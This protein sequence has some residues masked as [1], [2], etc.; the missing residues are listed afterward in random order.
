MS[1]VLR[2]VGPRPPRVYWI[3]RLVLLAAVVLVLALAWSLVSKAFGA[4][5]A[6]DTPDDTTPVAAAEADA[7]AAT[8]TVEQPADVGPV[9]C[10]AA[11]LTVTLTT[12]ARSYPAGAQPTFT[13]AVTN[14]GTIPCTVDAAATQRELVV[15][16]GADR[17]WSSLD[18]SPDPAANLLLLEP[19]GRAD[20]PVV[21]DRTR[22]AAGC[23]G[24]LPEPGAGT[25]SAVVSTLGATSGAAVFEL[26]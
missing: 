15:T 5:R 3:R 20:T 21:W 22:S 23:P 13:V 9:A 4:G 17:I 14:A 25:Y 7:E 18:C 2:P 1:T 19:G 10:A 16:S 26:G 12:D 6:A 11:D 24:G 8:E